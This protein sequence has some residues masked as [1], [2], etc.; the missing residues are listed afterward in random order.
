M[1]DA[2]S[3]AWRFLC[4]AADFLVPRVITEDVALER[5]GPG[6]SLDDWAISWRLQDVRPGEVFDAVGTVDSFTWLGFGI[7]YRMGNVRPWPG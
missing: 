3:A 2:A 7:T 6:G 4:Y 1:R 5:I